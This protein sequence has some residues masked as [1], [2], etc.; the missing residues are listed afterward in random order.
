MSLYVR[1]TNL[2]KEKADE[3]WLTDSQREIYEAILTRWRSALFVNLYGLPGAGKTFIARLLAKKHGYVYS[4]DLA[5]VSDGAEQVIIDDA[6][7]TRMM[8]PLARALG[9]QR[10]LLIT[11]RPIDEAMPKIGLALDVRDVAQF[12]ARLSQSCGI[13]FIETMPEGEDLG[14]SSAARR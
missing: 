3:P 8:R 7:Y 9:V 1:W 6:D 11:E 13:T 4:H 5:K 10:V 2:I 14:E 12:Q